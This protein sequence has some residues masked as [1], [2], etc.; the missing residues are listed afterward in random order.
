MNWLVPAFTVAAVLVALALRDRAGR[1]L[2]PALK[3]LG[4]TARR[5]F[6]GFLLVGALG[7]ALNAVFTLTTRW[8][9]P[10]IHDEF[11][12]LL[13]ADTFA[14][15]RLTNPPHPMWEHLE[16]MHILVQPTYASKYP[17]AQGMILAAGQVLCGKPIVG[18]WLA[19]ALACMAVYWALLAWLPGRWALLGGILSAMHPL[20]LEWGQ[21]F[22]G[23]AAAMM[24]GALVF[25]A[26]RRITRCRSAAL[27]AAASDSDQ[28]K[29]PANETI[30]SPVNQAA[31]HRPALQ[32]TG[33]NPHP[34]DSLAMGVGLVI[35]ANS[36]PFEGFVFGV[37][38]ALALGLWLLRGR[39]AALRR[40]ADGPA[41]RP[42]HLIMKLA[43]P[44][45]GVLAAGGLWMG[46]YNYRVTGD[47]MRFPYS[48]HEATYSMTPLF[49]WQQ[50]KPEPE[51]RHKPL[52]D[53]WTGWALDFHQRQQSLQGWA[54]DCA[55]KLW[56]F[57]KAYLW[58]LALLPA[59][60]IA[61]RH[62]ITPHPASGH[63][64]HSSDEGRGKGEGCCPH[65]ATCSNTA[66]SPSTRKE[67][68]CVLLIA[69]YLLLLLQLSW[70]LQPHYA[71]PWFAVFLLLLLQGLRR[72]AVGSRGWKQ[73]SPLAAFGP[74]IALGLIAGCLVSPL[75]FWQAHARSSEGNF[76]RAA[77]IQQ[78]KSQGGAHL[79][80]V[81]YADD[82]S[83]HDEWVYNDAD[84]PESP[85]VWARDLGEAKNRR[86]LEHFERRKAWLLEPDRK[87]RELKPYLPATP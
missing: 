55:R 70:P 63:P 74:G 54:F 58:Q 17:P 36:R 13:A 21:C 10:G 43:L 1:W 52:R 26:Y 29:P 8:P 75:F 48:E 72:L 82:H 49:V 53:F 81:R 31:G 84:I 23:G 15:G 44:T 41:G 6:A 50:A 35:L 3:A 30:I 7:L 39:D 56:T 62:A 40:P 32:P 9:V 86:L 2:K 77:M 71:A 57:S 67:R 87:P 60:L 33:I 69:G 42:Y 24:G 11:S 83:P 65:D 27:R 73:A 79:V 5:R 59:L 14:Q 66:A 85:V 61:L 34:C 51:Y 38:I 47:P 37:L 4:V 64:L 46:C 80:I 16:S 78:L 22:W 28:A 12:Y 76:Q 25:G 20:V 18:A 45:A 68:F 19:N